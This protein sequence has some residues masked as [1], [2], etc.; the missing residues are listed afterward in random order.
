MDTSI[1]TSED[2]VLVLAL[3]KAGL[4]HL[5][6]TKALHEGLPSNAHAILLGSQDDAITGLH[7]IT[8][9]DPSLRRVMEWVQRGA[10]QDVFT[11]FYR[12]WLRDKTKLVYQQLETILDQQVGL[13][14]TLLIVSTH[15]GLAH[16][17]AAIKETLEKERGIK[18]VL[19]NV[20]T[21]DSPQHI[22]AIGGAD[23]V[24][25]PSKRT[26]N[27][28]EKY[29]ESQRM[30]GAT[31]VTAPYVVSPHLAEELTSSQMEER[32]EQARP[33]SQSQI[34]MAIP[35]SG[36]A[37]QLT[38]FTRLMDALGAKSERYR[39][40]V[41]SKQSK[42]T[43][44]FIQQL[45]SRD[46]TELLVSDKDREVVDVYEELYESKRVLLEVTKPSEQSFK[47]LLPPN[48]VGGSILLFSDPVGR[49]EYDNVNF[50]RRHNVMPD[51]DIQE[52]L[53]SAARQGDE[54]PKGL[55][56]EVEK[57]IHGWR[58]LRLPKGAQA[59]A[60]FIEWCLRQRLFTRMLRFEGYVD[61]PELS[62]D[63]ARIFWEKVAEYLGSLE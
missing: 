63:G 11:Y 26:K 20:V 5:R 13:P 18:V 58:A 37:V 35:I 42:H 10:P 57:E 14:K 41:V 62:P 23:L 59:S 44:S 15:F 48:R 61:H 45:L 7:R 9:V 40:Y 32:R 16:Q 50:L 27:A 56:K 17:I 30:P 1:L 49:Q 24:F 51:K 54:M 4:G 21:D 19:V 46:D 2:V 12:N 38:Y 6:V 3:A 39:F 8:S 60:E 55:Q 52:R 36:A 28:L 25:V 53:W 33:A 22:W 31:Y 43:A 34:R 47:A 29:H